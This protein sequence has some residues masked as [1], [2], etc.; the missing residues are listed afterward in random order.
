VF[1]PKFLPEMLG[2]FTLT[3]DRW[4]IQQEKD[5]SNH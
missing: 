1:E 5:Q 4:H 2:D 3:V